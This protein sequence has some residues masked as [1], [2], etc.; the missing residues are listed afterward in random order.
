MKKYLIITLY[1]LTLF[2]GSVGYAQTTE[3]VTGK[4]TTLAPLPGTTNEAGCTENCTADINSYL[5]GFLGLV[6]SIG[7]ILAMVYLGIYG[8]QYAVSD[9]APKK[10]E[11]KDKIWE[12][13]QGLLLILAA[14]TIIY[15]INPKFVTNISIEL[16]SPKSK[17][18]TPTESTGGSTSGSGTPTTSTAPTSLQTKI[19]ETC[20]NCAPL[21]GTSYNI[22]EANIQRLN[23]TTC[24]PFGNLPILSGNLNKNIEPGMKNLLSALNTGLGQ[25]QISWGVTEAYPPVTN[26]QD[27]CHYVGTCIDAKL[28][29]P[30]A[31]NVRAFI[32]TASN[33]GLRAQFEVQTDSERTSMISQLQQLGMSA[34]E[35]NAAVI[36]VSTINGN[37]FSVY[38]R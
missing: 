21:T 2:T 22:S 28:S 7:A 26:H 14:Y 1:V 30:S 23:C 6:I 37:H 10:S 17:V 38:K 20:P 12:I 8:F 3:L 32:A 11:Y 34:T 24:I 16:T 5:S 18:F 27:N 19:T 36:K 35:A 29:N 13:L 33:N 9:S 15:T 25:Q 31:Q 4:Y